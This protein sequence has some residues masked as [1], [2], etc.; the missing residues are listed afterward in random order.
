MQNCEGAGQS[1][2]EAHDPQEEPQAQDQGAWVRT[3]AA[4]SHC[5]RH[6]F[7]QE[8]MTYLALQ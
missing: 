4:E 7:P 2:M 1:P 5:Q 3:T 8:F 6:P